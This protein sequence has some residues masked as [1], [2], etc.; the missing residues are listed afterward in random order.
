MLKASAAKGYRNPSF[1]EMYLYRPA[2]PDLDPE[3]M[4]SYEVTIGKT[5]SRYFGIDVTGYFSE[6][7]NMIQTVDMKNV[8]TGSFRNKG[9]EV[10][11]NSR[12][13]DKLTLRA[14]YSYLHTSL[15]NLTAAPK[16]QYYFGIGWQALP[17]LLVDAELRGIGG[18]YVSDD[19]KHQSPINLH[20]QYHLN[21][22]L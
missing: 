18:L 4:M 7:S 17:K 2:N 21:Y 20:S 11:A 12:P 14:T 13:T 6:G 16:N 15:D 22:L 10:S 3:N 1:R 9:I 5:F 8:N 19:T